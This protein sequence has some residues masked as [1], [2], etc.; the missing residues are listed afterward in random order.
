[1]PGLTRSTLELWSSGDF[2]APGLQRESPVDLRIKWFDRYGRRLGTCSVQGVDIGR[3][4]V[5]N[6]WALAYRR[7]STAYVEDEDYAREHQLGLWSGA[8][9]APWDWRHRD[10]GTAVLGALT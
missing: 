8:F 3:W 1:M 9:I 5:R 4:R 2:L 7:Y 10:R 6:G